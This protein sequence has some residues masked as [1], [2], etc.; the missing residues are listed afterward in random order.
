MLVAPFLYLALHI[1]ILPRFYSIIYIIDIYKIYKQFFY[2]KIVKK[3]VEQTY[4]NARVD[5]E[6]E[7]LYLIRKDMYM[8]FKDPTFRNDLVVQICG[9]GIN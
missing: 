9:P 7:C 8:R 2:R 6:H 4:S 5:I 3:E 1:S